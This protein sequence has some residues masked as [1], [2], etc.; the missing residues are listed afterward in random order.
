MTHFDG[1]DEKKEV[2]KQKE[3]P[4]EG[5]ELESYQKDGARRIMVLSCEWKFYLV[6]QQRLKINKSSVLFVIIVKVELLLLFVEIAN[7]RTMLVATFPHIKVCLCV[8]VVRKRYW[9]K[10]DISA[11]TSGVVNVVIYFFVVAEAAAAV[12]VKVSG[13]WFELNR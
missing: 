10:Q 2:Q 4:K 5:M 7:V 3:E 6:A 12:V 8:C 13:S 9:N 1:G 11:G